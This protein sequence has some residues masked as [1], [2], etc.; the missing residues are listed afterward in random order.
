MSFKEVFNYRMIRKIAVSL[1][2]LV[3]AGP[4]ILVGGSA[5][6]AGPSSPEKSVV[7]EDVR[8]DQVDLD[9]FRE[10]LRRLGEIISQTLKSVTEGTSPNVA[11]PTNGGLGGLAPEVNERNVRSIYGPDGPTVGSVQA[12]LGYRLVLLGNPRL[13][14]GP[15]YEKDGWI[16]AEIVTAKEQALVARYM[17]NKTTGVWVPQR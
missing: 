4:L 1:V 8:T 16:S 9:S 17:V 12:L 3:L 13:K 7:Q 15:V 2:V 6:S 14:A 5:I 10:Q 11:G